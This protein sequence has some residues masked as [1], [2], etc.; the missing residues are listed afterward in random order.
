MP[1]QRDEQEFLVLSLFLSAATMNAIQLLKE[2]E[3]NSPVSENTDQLRRS[4]SSAD[5]K[6]A[7]PIG[8]T[9]T[10]PTGVLGT[11]RRVDA[12]GSPNKTKYQDIGIL[13]TAT[14]SQ[15]RTGGVSSTTTIGRNGMYY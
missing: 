7:I 4:C 8:K 1:Y 10:L 5:T 13:L 9:S 12:S 6:T 15:P 11:V 14:G 2:F 3:T